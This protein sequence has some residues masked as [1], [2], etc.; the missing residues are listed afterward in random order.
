M[1]IDDRVT[2]V[3]FIG[4]GMMGEPMAGNI[5]AKGHTLVVYDID[6]TKVDHFVGLGA[7]AATGAAD[8]SRQART[9]VS[10]VDTTAQAESVITGL[11]G[12]I[13]SALPGDVIISM[14]TIDPIALRRMHAKLDAKGVLFID[15]PVSGMEKGA[16]EGTLKAFVGG[17]AEALEAARPVLQ[18]MTSEILHFGAIGQGTS[19]KLI[20]NMLIQV[21]WVVGAEA[22]ALGTKAGLDPAQM[23]EVIGKATG[24][25]VAFQYA[26]PRI[27]ARNF[28]GIRMDITF[29]DMELQIDL[30]KSLQFP[31]FM[32]PVAQQM[33]QMARAAGLGSE[34]GGAAI[35]K[36][37]ETMAGVTV[38]P[39]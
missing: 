19:M 2:T 28:E 24:N 23:V 20:N 12:L 4:L 8:V 14:G 21:G 13:D 38:A 27:L 5:L 3:G 9:V 37:Y 7:R 17:T 39:N 15:A 1:S 26:A 31:M 18:T 10:M 36:V 22:L 30:A 32:A 11:G 34:D 29:K 6:K 16:R 35:V 33:Y 25:S